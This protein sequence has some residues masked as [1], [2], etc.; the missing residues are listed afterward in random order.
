MVFP[1]PAIQPGSKPP[2]ALQHSSTTTNLRI[3][4]SNSD[5]LASSNLDFACTTCVF[6]T[7]IRHPAFHPS[8]FSGRFSCDTNYF[9]DAELSIAGKHHLSPF[10][11]PPSRGPFPVIEDIPMESLLSLLCPE[12][13]HRLTPCDL[14]FCSF[15]S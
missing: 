7:L 5:S 10:P 8:P 15:R 6:S 2:M 12:P 1:H 13:S 14:L 9:S 4:R 11:I 3:T